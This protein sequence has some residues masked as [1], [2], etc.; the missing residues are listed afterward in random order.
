MRNHRPRDRCERR[1]NDLQDVA[2]FHH[3]VQRGQHAEDADHERPSRRAQQGHAQ[4]DEKRGVRRDKR[5]VDVLF[6]A[7]H[8]TIRTGSIA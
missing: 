3:I 4:H 7:Q 1:I 5:K 2:I 6:D 8:L